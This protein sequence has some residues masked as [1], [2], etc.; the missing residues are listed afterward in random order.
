MSAAERQMSNA[1]LFM[2]GGERPLQVSRLTL[3][4]SIPLMVVVGLVR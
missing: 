1:R 3:P 2:Y 4:V